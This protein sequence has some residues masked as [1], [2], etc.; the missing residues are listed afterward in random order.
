MKTLVGFVIFFSILI[1]TYLFYE[2]LVTDEREIWLSAGAYLLG[3]VFPI[4]ILSIVLVGGSFGDASIIKRTELMLRHTIPRHLQYIP[5]EE[6]KFDRFGRRNTKKNGA[7]E[8]L[9]I[10]DVHHS[11]GRCYADYLV[12]NFQEH[13]FKLHIRLELNV[14]RVNVVIYFL[15]Q[16]IDGLMCDQEFEG[17]PI[18]FIKSN[19]KHTLAVEALQQNIP[20]NYNDKDSVIAYSFNPELLISKVGGVEHYSL[21]ATTLISE[22]LVWNPSERVFF[23]QDLMFM[24]RSLTSEYDPAFRTEVMGDKDAT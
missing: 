20:P 1:C 15:K 17:R 11:S 18:D 16:Q 4:G 19:F 10:I 23:A 5:Q 12:S 6:L 13:D 14:K 24:M 3:I 7:K 8:K 21:V 22:D 9:A 2:A